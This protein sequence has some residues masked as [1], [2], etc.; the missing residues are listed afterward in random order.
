M[1]TSEGGA[2][3][4]GKAPSGLAHVPALDGMRAL[5][6]LAVVA[7]H[8]TTWAHGGFLGVD[9]FFALS[10][11]FV[12][13]VLAHEHARTGRI[14]LGRFFVRRARRLL[15]AL[16]LVCAAYLA[17]T[18]ALDRERFVDH[19]LDAGAALLGVANVPRVLGVER[20]RYLG[21]TWSLS[22]EQ[23]FYLVWGLAFA[24]LAP[25][26]PSPRR[27]ALVL[28]GL[29][30][31]AWASRLAAIANGASPERL[32]YM[33]DMR[34]DALLLGCALGVLHGRDALPRH[35]SSGTRRALVAALAAA[36]VVGAP[37]FVRARWNAPASHAWHRS[38][39]ALA[40]MALV[41]H[42]LLTPEGRLARALSARPLT[43]LGERSYGLYLWHFPIFLAL[44]QDA[45]LPLGTT[46]VVGS[47][48]S[49]LAAAA[50][51]RWVEVRLLARKPA[52]TGASD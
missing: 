19:L 42:L 7:Y 9:V 20:P 40:T 22:L 50:S 17:V 52:L 16:L 18:A 30:A 43:W 44:V 46:L 14:A 29:A 6:V 34:A 27:L 10:G 48:A 31:A 28:A 21:P 32:Y 35:V 2:T 47:A 1:G 26:V 45:R 12:T 5:A 24:W 8:G 23:H 36:A 25:R 38:F 13:A 4:A 39:V 33:L 15:P 51:Y 37:L 49:L 3:S 41:L 11:F